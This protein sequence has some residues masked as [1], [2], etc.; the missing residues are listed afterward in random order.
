VRREDFEVIEYLKASHP[1][2]YK[3]LRK[4][5]KSRRRRPEAEATE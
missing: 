1:D 3:N 4:A 2:L 5:V